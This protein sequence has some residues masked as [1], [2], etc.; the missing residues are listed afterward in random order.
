MTRTQRAGQLTPVPVH[1]GEAASPRSLDGRTSDGPLRVLVV[2]ESFL[3]QVNGVTNSVRRVLDHLADRGH[4]ALL[5]APSGPASYAGF[6]VVQARG[7]ALPFYPEFRIGLESRRRLRSVVER[8]DPDVLHLASPAT[9]GYQALKVGAETGV[10]AVAVYQTDLVGFADRYRMPGGARAMTELT[11]RIHRGAERTLAPSSASIGQLAE[12]GVGRVHLWPRGVDLEQFDPGHRDQALRDRLAPHGERLVGYV[13][14][15]APEKELGLLTWIHDLP[16][17]RL[18]IV[19]GG[20]E[21][22]RLRTLLPGAAFLGVR[23][24]TELSAAYA[25]LD[26]F[27]HTGRHE[28]FGQT[29]Q[30]ALASGVPV[31]AP[32]SGGPL[33]TVTDQVTGVL[34][35]PGDGAALLRE[36]LALLRDDRRRTRMA[37]AARRSVLGRGWSQVNDRLID[38]YRGAVASVAPGSAVLPAA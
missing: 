31:V 22:H 35:P 7:T 37:A 12:L 20:P 18:V 15:L 36:T 24:G 6:E 32:E 14:R 28:T 11:R 38:H 3:P 4:R 26:L 1:R 8:F 13:G 33:D 34:F 29:V 16:G 10:P 27:V 5:V 30:E 2:A 17:V 19:G 25:S 9:L 23:H 21:E